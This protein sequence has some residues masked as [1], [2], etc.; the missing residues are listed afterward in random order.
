M[1]TLGQAAKEARGRAGPG[2]VLL[3]WTQSWPPLLASDPW[4]PSTS[5]THY[6]GLNYTLPK[7]VR[8]S[9]GP[10]PQAAT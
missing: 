2:K 10:T 6:Y 4:G 7:P 3:V 5:E 9:P 1:S 8:G